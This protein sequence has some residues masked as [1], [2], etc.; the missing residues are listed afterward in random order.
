VFIS[1]SGGCDSLVLL[2][3]KLFNGG[4]IDLLSLLD[5]G[6][7]PLLDDVSD[8]SGLLTDS[9]TFLLRSQNGFHFDEGRAD[10]IGK[11]LE[12][13]LDLG[14]ERCGCVLEVHEV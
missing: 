6:T 2:A 5:N 12:G 14:G 1:V 11:G 9:D 3:H 7:D 4:G 8:L 13:G 10:F